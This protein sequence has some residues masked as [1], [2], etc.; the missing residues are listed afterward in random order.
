MKKLVKKTVRITLFFSCLAIG[1]ISCD[2]EE[3]TK[4]TTPVITPIDTTKKDTT[5][6][7]QGT[8][9]W[10]GDGSVKCTPY[11]LNFTP[12]VSLLSINT[13]K[14][15]N[16]TYRPN[17]AFSFDTGSFGVGSFTVVQK[18]SQNL[19]PNEVTLTISQYNYKN[20]KG[21]GGTVVI[22]KYAADTSKWVA[23]FNKLDLFSSTDSMNYTFTGRIENF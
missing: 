9:F 17:I 1:F 10:T 4:P 19:G 3:D 22:S 8:Q 7:P 23:T 2:K 14:C 6:A 16:E 13:E 18:N 20:Y 12:I 15:Y 5:A 21:T 11:T